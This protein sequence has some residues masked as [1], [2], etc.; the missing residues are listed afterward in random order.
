MR[1]RETD[2]MD[3]CMDGWTDEWMND[4]VQVAG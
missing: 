4:G 1:E 3:E 2:W